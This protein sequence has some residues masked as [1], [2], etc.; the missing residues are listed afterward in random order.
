MLTK[1]K[2]APGI[3]KQDT[4]VG[5]DGRW[6]DSDNVRFRYGLPEKVGGWQS[7]LTDT[8][9]GVARKMHAFVDQDGNRYVAIGTDKFLLIYF[10]GQLYDIT[11]TKAKI[12]T[13]AMSNADATKEVSLTFSAAHNLEE[14]DII[15]LDNVT[16]PTG[17][18]LTDAAFE[19]KLFQVTRLTSDL[20]AV[21]TGTET[22]T[23]VGSGGTCDVTPYERVGPAAQSYGYGFGVTQ[24]GG[25]VQGSASSTLN[26]GISSIVIMYSNPF[27]SPKFLTSTLG[28]IA[29]FKFFFCITSLEDV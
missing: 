10:E 27:S 12:T 5:A 26:S 29:N 15:Y 8:A 1:I 7:L 25:T 2:F 13:V 14:G 19:G 23:G 24:F 22:T 20:I 18:G 3:D 16:V 21:I 28:L 9:V 4:A 6:V 11:P 17:V